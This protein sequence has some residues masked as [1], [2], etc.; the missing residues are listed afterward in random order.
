VDF[1]DD[2]LDINITSGICQFL[3]GSLVSWSS[4]KQTSVA[5]STAEAGYIAAGSCCTQIL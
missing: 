5:L 4:H 1:I 2:R 3:G